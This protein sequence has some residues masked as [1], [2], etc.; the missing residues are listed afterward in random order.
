LHR[1]QSTPMRPCPAGDGTLSRA[2]FATLHLIA[3]VPGANHVATSFAFPNRVA[4]FAAVRSAVTAL[5]VSALFG[6][7]R[8]PPCFIMLQWQ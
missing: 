3:F 7:G 6:V 2:A 1:Q 5:A 4:D 8:M